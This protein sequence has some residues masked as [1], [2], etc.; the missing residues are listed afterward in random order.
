MY[1][2]SYVIRLA[3][4]ADAEALGRLAGLDAQAPLEGRILIGE[5]HGE[6]VAALSLLDDR[7]IANPF[8]PTAHLLATM[9]MRARGLHAVEEIPSLRERLLAG[10]P[11]TYRTRAAGR[12]A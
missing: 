6:P 7:V 10:L 8:Q 12:G 5:L 4:A 2:N 9:R 1:V 11:M 3:T